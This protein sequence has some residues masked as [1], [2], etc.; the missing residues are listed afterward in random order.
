[1]INKNDDFGLLHQRGPPSAS[2]TKYM[3][4]V[5][6]ILTSTQEDT[7]KVNFVDRYNNLSIRELM[8]QIKLL[9]DIRIH[10][11]LYLK[12]LKKFLADNQF[13]KL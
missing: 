13:I 8:K 11:K 5:N 3:F 12:E 10:K 9:K 4:K 1:M 2:N 7:F 6:H